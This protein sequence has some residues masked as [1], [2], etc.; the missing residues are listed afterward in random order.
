[1][2]LAQ[3]IPAVGNMNEV[4]TSSVDNDRRRT[5]MGA[6]T[7]SRRIQWT[8]D[9]DADLVRCNDSITIPRGSGR[10]CE[11]VRCWLALHPTASGPALSTCLCRIRQ[12]GVVCPPV[13]TKLSP[14]SDRDSSDS[15]ST[16][17]GDSGRPGGNAR[18]TAHS[19]GEATVSGS[20]WDESSPSSL[21]FSAQRQDLPEALAQSD[22]NGDTST[23]DGEPATKPG[24]ANA[25]AHGVDSSALRWTLQMQDGEELDGSLSEELDEV[26]PPCQPGRDRRSPSLEADD[27]VIDTG[28]DSGPNAENRTA[29]SD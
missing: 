17:T 14:S 20:I 24:P 29:G 26:S 21:D 6:T 9:L 13:R 25:E 12:L 16:V 2:R 23:S 15:L 28:L 3:P 1:M 5:E 8:E 4:S 11:L 18:L 22:S 10:Q 27:P 19:V 7:R